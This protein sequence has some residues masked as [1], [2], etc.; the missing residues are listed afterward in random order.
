MTPE[1][2]QG[3]VTQALLTALRSVE[4]FEAE[5]AVVLGRYSEPPDNRLPFAALSPPGITSAQGPVLG[6]YLRTVVYDV[7]V[8]DSVESSDASD[9]VTEAEDLLSDILEALERE[10]ANP[11]S[12]LYRLPTFATR[13]AP[14]IAAI[15]P[16]PANTV[17]VFLAIELTYRRARGLK[18]AS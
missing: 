16:L 15:D 5:G 1:V 17:A 7:E 8:W 10:R 14:L 2:D 13:A 3:R 4:R 9:Q 12:E 6:S 11:A 18:G